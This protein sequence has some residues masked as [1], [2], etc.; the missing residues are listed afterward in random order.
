MPKFATRLTWFLASTVCVLA[1]NAALAAG[2][3]EADAETV[4]R[5]EVPA[6]SS[7]EDSTAASVQVQRVSAQ[8][9]TERARGGNPLWEIPLAVLS[10]TRERPVF[11]S[12][13]RPPPVVVPQVAL[14]KPPPP[15]KL[16]EE[17]S[18]Q[19][20]LV[21]TVAGGDQRFGIFVDQTSKAALRLRVG[22]EHHGWRLRAVRGR[23]ATFARDQQTI[24]LNFPEPGTVTPAPPRVEVADVAPSAEEPRPPHVH[25]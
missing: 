11:S 10:S 22:D 19:L 21:G 12:S 18:P 15:P 25:R 9:P 17:E 23:E 24:V 6:A 1:S 2:N 16:P 3:F 4:R 13:R 14:A 20:L 7:L 5:V 8:Q